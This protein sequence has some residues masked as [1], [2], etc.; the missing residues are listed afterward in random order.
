MMAA[1]CRF[2]N[3]IFHNRHSLVLRKCCLKQYNSKRTYVASKLKLQEL[4]KLS[5]SAAEEQQPMP[6]QNPEAIFAN[7]ELSLQKIEVYGFDYDYTLATYTPKLHELIFT[8]GKEALVDKLKYP[9]AILDL[10]YDADFA[11]RGLHYDV[12]KGLFM[13]IDQFHNI[14]LGTVY[15]GMK[16]VPDEEVKTLFE[17]THISVENMNTFYGAGPM[18]QMVDLFALP[19]ITLVSLV[20]EY[21]SN[22]LSQYFI[23]NNIT[24][25]PEYV[26]FDIRN[27]VQGIHNSG[28]LHQAIIKDLDL[29]LYSEKCYETKLLLENLRGEGKKLFLISN[30]GFPFIDHGMKY[31]VGK[32]WQELFDVVIVNARKPKFFKE[33]YR[34]FRAYNMEQMAP[35]WGRVTSLNK[36]VVYNQGN[37]HE[38]QE[39][40]GWYGPKVLY[41]GDHIYSDLA[42]PSLKY[43]WRTGAIIPELEAEINK[44]NSEIYKSSVR[45]LVALQH[46]I[47]DMQH[48]NSPESKEV[49][50]KWIEERN[51]LRMFTKS[52]FNP[53]FGSLFRTYHNPTYFFR[54][55]ARFAD[56][57]TSNLTNLLRY[58]TS[59]TFYPHRILL[60]HE[61]SVYSSK[62]N[63][64]NQGC[65]NEENSS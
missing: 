42:D 29:Y 18:H 22:C 41:F 65:F 13:K 14:Q 2:W 16:P 17:G 39:L 62:F 27:T 35:E 7:N 55:L 20:T 23:A 58:S 3:L 60:P 52:L 44:Q 26:F 37:H 15:R 33:G 11:V 43:G 31:M 34:P 4:Y 61:P 28:Q 1:T 19:E 40:T 54:R 51:E 38:L 6:D 36:G 56:I 48:Q 8:L 10:E 64:K 50:N 63:R 21:I 47:D 25:D 9:E 57:Y 24:Y 30:S 32:E 49:I 53:H 46:L 5:K 12:K 59:Y 45:W